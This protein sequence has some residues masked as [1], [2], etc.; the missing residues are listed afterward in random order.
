MGKSLDMIQGA[1]KSLDVTDVVIK[2]CLIVAKLNQACYLIVDHFIWFG[3]ISNAKVDI[4]YW[5]K[6]AAQFWLVTLVFNLLRNLYDILKL[7]HT[8]NDSSMSSPKRE[9]TLMHSML[10]ENKAVTVDTVKNT[11]DVFLPLS[12]LG[13][14]NIS[15]GTQGVLG[16]I[17]SLMAMLQTWHADYKVIPS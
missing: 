5:N 16:M 2:T 1:L 6:V 15:S 8:S 3:K 11:C 17:S 13:Y 10:H 12:T 7:L 9:N 14:S 4:K